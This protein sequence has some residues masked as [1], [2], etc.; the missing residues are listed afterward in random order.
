LQELASQ[1]AD[2]TDRIII[3]MEDLEKAIKILL[4]VVEGMIII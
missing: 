3:I 2:V 4:L 1:K